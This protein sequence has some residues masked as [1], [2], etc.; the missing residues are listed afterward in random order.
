MTELTKKTYSLADEGSIMSLFD[1]LCGS[2]PVIL[3]LDSYYDSPLTTKTLEEFIRD[4]NI[5]L[6]YRGVND[7]RKNLLGPENPAFVPRSSSWSE[8]GAIGEGLYLTTYYATAKSYAVGY[9]D[10]LYKGGKGC[11]QNIIILGASLGNDPDIYK[12]V[13]GVCLRE[14]NKYNERQEYWNRSISNHEVSF[15]INIDGDGTEICFFINPDNL[16]HY[17]TET[18]DTPMDLNENICNFPFNRVPTGIRVDQS[19][20]EQYPHE[21]LTNTKIPCPT[22]CQYLERTNKLPK[23]KDGTQIV[24]GTSEYREVAE[25]RQKYLKYKNKYLE[26]KNKLDK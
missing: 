10:T 24:C 20:I 16:I 15:V 14:K 23:N 25:Y 3:L 11:S 7:Y 1:Y 9:A 4:V 12:S 18:K 2:E 6:L 5:P 22:S 26:L 13:K 8:G 19:I 21:C 17:I